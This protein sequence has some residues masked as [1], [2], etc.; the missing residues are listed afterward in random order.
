MRYIILLK[1]V[2]PPNCPPQVFEGIMKLGQ[3]ASSSGAMVDNA[4]LAPATAGARVSLRA[5]NVTVGDILPDRFAEVMSYAIYEVASKDE[6][7]EWARRFLQL[8]AE[9]L[10]DW[11]ADAEVLKALGPEDMGAA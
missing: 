5:G 3:E 11:E 9:H 8:H 4:G 10:P 7:V 2:L 6:A 1:G